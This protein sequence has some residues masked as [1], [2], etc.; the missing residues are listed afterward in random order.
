VAYANPK[1]LIVMLPFLPKLVPVGRLV[2]KDVFIVG[3][4]ILLLELVATVCYGVAGL[5]LRRLTSSAEGLLWFNRIAGTLV[6]A[7]AALIL[8]AGLVA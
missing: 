8:Y 6:V 2:S 1:P 7:S 3:A 4:L 5:R